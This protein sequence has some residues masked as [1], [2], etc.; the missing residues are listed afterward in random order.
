MGISLRHMD[1]LSAN[2]ARAR[3]W[4]NTGSRTLIFWY[5]LLTKVLNE[6]IRVNSVFYLGFVFRHSSH[7]TS[8]VWRQIGCKGLTLLQWS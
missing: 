7:T 8:T 2:G 6:I 5:A 4:Q 3:P 1:F